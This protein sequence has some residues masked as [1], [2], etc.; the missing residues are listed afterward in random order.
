LFTTG[1][2]DCNFY[3][4]PE[5]CPSTTT[6]NGTTNIQES[7]VRTN[8]NPAN[9][10]GIFTPSNVAT[11]D[12]ND[13]DLGSGGALLL[14]TQSGNVPYLAVG[15][16]KDGRL[17]LLN[18]LSMSSPLDTHQ[19]GGCWCGPSY[20]VGS[21]QVGRIVTS[22]GNTISTWSLVLSPSPHLV[23]EGNV[24]IS[25]GQDPGFFT[26]VSS[27]GTTA[28]TGIIWAVGHPTSATSGIQLFAFA[29]AASGGTYK[30]LFSSPAGPWPY[31]S[32]NANVVPVVANGKVYVASN[33]ALTI[34]GVRAGGAALIAAQ[35]VL[36]PSPVA[37]P[38][39]PHVVTGTLL[40]VSGSTLTLQTHGAKTV[41]IDDSQ[42]ARNEQ[43][44]G[45]L[46]IGEPLTVQG[47]ALTGAG[48][49]LATSIVRA[50]GSGDL[51]PPDH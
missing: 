41:K 2:S 51:W 37:S 48:A 18:R 6:Y 43:I 42:A 47:S 34:F 7:I 50:K 4:Y 15:A 39:S 32:H 26:V 35:T 46:T 21:D 29:A 30:L 12:K 5:Q 9:L 22:Q 40:E 13:T 19:L 11:L 10:L 33:K 17:F 14:P 20:F 16:G 24:N 49:L 36:Q 38:S 44:M 3:V 28:G 45:P 25:T 31:T 1:N 8:E 27:N 23:Q